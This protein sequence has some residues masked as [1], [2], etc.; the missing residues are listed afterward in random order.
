MTNPVG[1]P[2]AFGDVE[3]LEARIDDYFA[4]N[5]Y[6]GEGDERIFAPTMAGLA[7]HL[8]VDR[9]TITNYANK[10][11]FFPTIKR[12]RGRVEEFLEQRLYGNT[13]TGVIFNLKNNFDWK[14]KQEIEQ[15]VEIDDTSLS[16]TERAAKLTAIL[17]AA[18]ERSARQ[19]DS[20]DASVDGS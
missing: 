13:V 2:L 20:D 16:N 9:K 10:E 19:S 8:D 7:R 1:R 3:E 12:A 6:M 4:T 18:R 15:K 5:A 14:D 11:E 17:D